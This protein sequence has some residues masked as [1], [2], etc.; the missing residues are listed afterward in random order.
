M[1][2]CGLFCLTYLVFSQS[3]IAGLTQKKTISVAMFENITGNKEY[4]WIG[5]GFAET[6]TT[7]LVNV[8][9]IIVVE[10]LK[11]LDVLKEQKLQLSG[12][13]DENT[14]IKVGKLIAAQYIVVGSF[15]KSGVE[16]KVV[17]RIVN[18][19]TARAEKSVTVE[20]KFSDIF[21]LQRKLTLE[22]AGIIE[23]PVSEEE[24]TEIAKPPARN[25]A[26]YEWFAKGKMYYYEKFQSDEA[27]ASYKKAIK[28]D[29]DYADA[30]F[31]LGNAFENKGFYGE[32]YESYKNA[33][34]LYEIKN[35]RLNMGKTLQ[36]IGIIFYT[37][38]NYDKAME[39][40][41]KSIAIIEKLENYSEMAKIYNNIWLIK[42]NR[43][44]YKSALEDCNKAIEINE[45]YA[46]NREISVGYCNIGS[47]YD[48]LGNYD[49]A[50]EFCN[51]AI[52][53]SRKIGY[54]RGLASA[55]NLAGNIHYSRENY[56]KAF[57]RFGKSLEINEKLGSEL[58]IV[59]NYI[60]LGA[61]Y[62]AN[63]KYVKAIDCYDKALKIGKKFSNKLNIARIYNNIGLVYFADGDYTSARKY[64]QKSFK[65]KQELGDTTGSGVVMSN[66]SLVFEAEKD[67]NSAVKYLEDAVKIFEK[68]EYYML[69]KSL[70]KLDDLR[71]KQH[72]KN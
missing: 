45:K 47:L 16:L 1:K 24:K 66:I 55:Y 48:T 60:N 35:N 67:Y 44:D 3:V 62:Y 46:N 9:S 31:E 5:T 71:K 29:K 56:D 30:Y 15:Q 18:V 43:G 32:A 42:Y 38:G 39:Y 53:I 52:E 21:E 14:A 27:I 13:V 59:E 50:M 6:V 19:E 7:K 11:L 51:K 54:Q 25:F 70:K 49:K 57:E 68:T 2:F 23:T 26:A 65:M 69:E 4:D 64:F 28:I 33:L 8:K 58:S 41:N 34:L 20:G 22:L 12:L 36:N 61:V 37:Q 40:Y 17:A 63:K 10:R 72:E